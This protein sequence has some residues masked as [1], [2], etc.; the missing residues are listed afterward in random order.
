MSPVHNAIVGH[1][2]S[3]VLLQR[4]DGFK[5]RCLCMLTLFLAKVMVS[6][7]Q[8]WAVVFFLFLG[9]WFL[10]ACNSDQAG[11][12][13][14]EERKSA[15]DAEA[16][17]KDLNRRIAMNATDASAYGERADWWLQRDRDFSVNAADSG[18]AA[19]A[20]AS[21]DQ[22]REALRKAMADIKSALL[23]DTGNALFYCILGEIYTRIGLISEADDALRVAMA[24]NPNLVRAYL[25]R[26]ELALINRQYSVA[27]KY[28]NEALRRDK[29]LAEAYLLKGMTHL[30]QKDTTAARSAW[31]TAIEQDPRLFAAYLELGL[32]E[33][34]SRLAHRY[35][36]NVLEIRPGHAEAL[37][38]RA[39]LLQG[40][41]YP[42]SARQDYRALLQL[43]K[44]HRDALFNLGYL[45][46][47]EQKYEQALQGF[48]RVLALQSGDLPALVNR[49]LCYEMMGRPAEASADYRE[50][51]RLQKGYPQALQ[52]LNRLK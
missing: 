37:Y 41:G 51:L 31:L 14:G 35:F 38:A 10:L 52:G 6:L 36:S 48:D 17:L 22:P 5:W 7:V 3:G 30:E 39:M 18:L 49:G 44:S 29:R 28:L 43:N 23:L 33:P 40:Q 24:R 26:G 9:F 20:E 8:R 1:A 27:F 50:C 15:P 19:A 11:Q 25:R 46:L 4:R 34:D 12:K 47:L 16:V 45:D 42:D 2:T 32:H 21:P 13:A